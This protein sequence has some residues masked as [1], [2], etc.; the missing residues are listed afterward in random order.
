MEKAMKCWKMVKQFFCQAKYFKNPAGE[1][2]TVHVQLGLWLSVWQPIADDYKKVCA[3]ACER[4]RERERQEVVWWSLVQDFFAGQN[5]TRAPSLTSTYTLKK[6]LRWLLCC[7]FTDSTNSKN[8]SGQLT[9][10]QHRR[11]AGDDKLLYIT[12]QSLKV[13][14]LLL[15]LLLLLLYIVISLYEKSKRLKKLFFKFTVRLQ[16]FFDNDTFLYFPFTVF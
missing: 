10:L 5:V 15:L 13:D 8:E 4:V 16:L 12:S 6:K 2:N 11:L 1:K 3:S 7:H 14:G 9:F